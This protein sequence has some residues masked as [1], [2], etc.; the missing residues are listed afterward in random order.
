MIKRF[1]RPRS[2]VILEIDA[3][4]ENIEGLTNS[5]VNCVRMYPDGSRLKGSV[6]F[7]ILR[8]LYIE[9]VSDDQETT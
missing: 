9:M 2:K 1:L 6:S 3:N 5:F 7:G 8:R 4:A